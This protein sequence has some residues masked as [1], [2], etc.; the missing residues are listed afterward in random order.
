MPNGENVST[1]LSL[2]YYVMFMILKVG[3]DEFVTSSFKINVWKILKPAGVSSCVVLGL[4]LCLWKCG[5]RLSLDC[6]VNLPTSD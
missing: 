4:G 2:S 6:D 5:C 3:L 1:F